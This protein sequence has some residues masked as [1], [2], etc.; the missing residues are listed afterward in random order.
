MKCVT[1]NVFTHN[2]VEGE[3]IK[4]DVAPVV[5]DRQN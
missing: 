4:T 5:F 1:Y 3:K 2:I